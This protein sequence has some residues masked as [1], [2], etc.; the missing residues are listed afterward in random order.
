MKRRM[1]ESLCFRVSDS[2]C[3]AVRQL[4]EAQERAIA[5]VARDLLNEGLRARGVEC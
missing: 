1:R 5:E 4:A 3:N 2:T